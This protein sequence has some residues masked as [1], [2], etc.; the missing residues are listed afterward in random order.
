MGSKIRPF[1]NYMKKTLLFS[2]LG[3][4]EIFKTAASNEDKSVYKI[5]NASVGIEAGFK[6]SINFGINTK[7]FIESKNKGLIF[8][9]GSES[10]IDLNFIFSKLNE[11]NRY[12][13]LDTNVQ[14]SLF[15]GSYIIGL[16]NSSALVGAS[17]GHDVS[18]L[19]YSFIP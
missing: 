7:S 9:A 1:K 19:S 13:R 17:E 6:S 10:S 4:S 15:K 8:D 14:F 16:N 5:N 2:V 11:E 3:I 18:A 12:N